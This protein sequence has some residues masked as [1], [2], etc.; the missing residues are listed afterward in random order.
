MDDFNISNQNNEPLS[1]YKGWCRF[2]WFKFKY[3]YKK[4]TFG[5]NTMS[6]IDKVKNSFWLDYP[7]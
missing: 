3:L 5:V 1:N 6:I 2:S 4:Y 7:Q